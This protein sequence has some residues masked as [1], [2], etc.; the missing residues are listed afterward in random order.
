MDAF[1]TAELAPSSEIA[2]VGCIPYE[3]EYEGYWRALRGAIQREEV[4]DRGATI[5]DLLID[6]NPGH[7]TAWEYRRKWAVQEGLVNEEIE[8]ATEQVVSNPKNYQVWHHHR[9][10]VEILDKPVDALELTQDSLEQDAKNYHAW[11][12]RQ[13]IVKKFDLFSNELEFV[14]K[15]IDADVRN[16]SAWNY[17]YFLIRETK[18]DPHS[19]VVEEPSLV[20][21][22]SYAIRKSR[23]APHNESPWNYIRALARLARIPLADV[24]GLVDAV[25]PSNPQT[26]IENRFT[27]HMYADILTESDSSAD[28]EAAAKLFQ[29]LMES[30]PCRRRFWEHKLSTL[31]KSISRP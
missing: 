15:L 23:L 24:V 7:Y 11:S 9:R 29:K 25:R 17:R 1:D 26:T 21:E 20:Q 19:R 22:T 4:S 3:K 12:Y 16:N 30:D 6:N 18:F 5:S 8:Y 28:K 13:W 2:P 14:S 10:L 31:Q 27:A